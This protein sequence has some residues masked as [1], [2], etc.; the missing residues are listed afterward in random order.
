MRNQIVISIMILVI[1]HLPL[2][3]RLYNDRLHLDSTHSLAVQ[4]Q[5][6]ELAQK[7]LHREWNKVSDSGSKQM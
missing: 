3:T 1:W 2:N 4:Q 6:V 7:R 5:S